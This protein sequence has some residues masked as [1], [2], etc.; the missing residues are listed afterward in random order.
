MKFSD[1]VPIVGFVNWSERNMPLKDDTPLPMSYCIQT[2][3]LLVYNYLLA[4]GSLYGAIK[5]ASYL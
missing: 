2:G 3:T 5:L 4:S 1:F